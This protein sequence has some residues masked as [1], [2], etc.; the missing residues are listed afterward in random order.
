MKILIC[1]GTRPEA[2]KMAPVCK[3]LQKNNIPFRICVTA[4]HREMLDQVLEFFELVPDYD[5]NLMQHD[6]TLNS[7]GAKILI[8]IDGILEKEKPDVVLVQGDTT[9]A[10]MV[11]FAAYNRKIKIGHI[12]AGLRTFNKLSP[13]PEEGFRQVISRVA[14]L[15]FAPTAGA[16]ENLLKENLRGSQIFV[17]GN[18]V[19]DALLWAVENINT[20]PTHQGLEKINNFLLSNKKLILVTGHRRENFGKGLNNICEALKELAERED[21]VIVYPVHPNPSVSTTVRNLLENVEN[22][23]LIDPL[24]YPSMLRLLE[25]TAL[26][27]SDSGGVQE[28]APSFGIPVIVTR[29]YTERIEGVEAGF[30]IITGNNKETILKEANR[31]LDNPPNLKGK[32]NPYG[33]GKAAEQIVGILLQQKF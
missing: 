33:D 19:V 12:E 25:K 30:C 22:I 11:S 28:E 24:N 15:H 4:Q 23:Y 13:F 7:L 8:E 17:T 1:F 27:I 20:G 2:I 21:V 9:T 26:A 6:Q 31:L 3:E 16:R 32:K 29:S 18:T 5:L 10:V 14:D